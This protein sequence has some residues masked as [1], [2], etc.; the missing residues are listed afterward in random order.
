MIV[1]IQV[2]D[3][4]LQHALE[5]GVRRLGCEARPLRSIRD[6]GTDPGVSTVLLDDGLPD[7]EALVSSFRAH[8]PGARLVVLSGRSDA[9]ALVGA[10]GLGVDEVLRKPV[11]LDDLSDALRAGVSPST[12]M[13]GI[14]AGDERMEGVLRRLAQAA[15]SELTVLL[16]GESGTG[17]SLLARSIHQHSARRRGAFVEVSPL[18]LREALA[19]AGSAADLGDGPGGGDGVA[20]AL[21]RRA[22]GGTL[23]L[24]GVDAFPPEAQESLLSFLEQR[25][26]RSRSDQ[27]FDARVIAISSQPLRELVSSRRLSEDLAG[28]LGVVSA[29]VPPLRERLGDLPVL[30]AVFL[31]RFAG[32]TAPAGV[33]GERSGAREP[34]GARS[35][36]LSGRGDSPRMDRLLAPVFLRAGSSRPQPETAGARRHRAFAR[37]RRW[38]PDGSGTGVGDQRENPAEQDPTVR[39]CLIEVTWISA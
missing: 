16:C 36:G 39:P 3:P 15:G 13:L 27:R 32:R 10:L 8:L 24:D 1:S 20:S 37:P 29:L 21:F 38:Q 14:A 9:R 6:V 2:R 17:R 18:E 22:C 33:E 26:A 25:D 35:G 23:V 12:A 30:A 11:D 31:E 4:A 28:R 34:D 5:D 7:L 19:L